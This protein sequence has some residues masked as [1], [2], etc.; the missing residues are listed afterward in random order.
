MFQQCVRYICFETIFFPTDV[1][2]SGFSVLVCLLPWNLL[3]E[4]LDVSTD[5]IAKLLQGNFRRE[6]LN[7]TLLSKPTK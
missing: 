5:K 3:S 7:V 2:S 4:N 1:S 6:S